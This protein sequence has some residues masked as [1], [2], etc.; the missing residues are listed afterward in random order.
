MDTTEILAK[1]TIAAA[2]ISSHAVEIPNIPRRGTGSPDAA[3]LRLR[4]L[5]EYVYQTIMASKS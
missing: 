2:L 3:G 1:A 4:E 5:T